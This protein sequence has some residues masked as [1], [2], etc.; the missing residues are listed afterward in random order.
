MPPHFV[1][2]DACRFVL[3]FGVFDYGF[4]FDTFSFDTVSVCCIFDGFGC[5]Y[6]G[7]GCIDDSVEFRPAALVEGAA[8]AEIHHAAIFTQRLHDAGFSVVQNVR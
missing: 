3:I 2:D 8:L 5:R 6:F 4:A 7:F 1:P